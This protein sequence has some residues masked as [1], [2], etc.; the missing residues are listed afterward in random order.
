MIVSLDKESLAFESKDF[1]VFLGL[2]VRNSTVL[3]FWSIGPNCN[4]KLDIDIGICGHIC[5]DADGYCCNC[6]E[7][8]ELCDIC[9]E[10]R[11][12]KLHTNPL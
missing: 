11:N 4:Y 12:D 2:P 7:S 5:R 6:V 1:S 3:G 10:A 8:Y 9:N